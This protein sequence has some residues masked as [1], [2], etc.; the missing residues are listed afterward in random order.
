MDTDIIPPMPGAYEA[1]AILGRIEEKVSH[2]AGMDERLRVVERA[3]AEL[4]AKQ[5]PK[6]SAFNVVAMV[7]SL[8]TGVGVL[9]TIV[10]VFT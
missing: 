8:L 1:G 9:V 5:T 7:V 3:V 2:L 6:V 4:T 10:A